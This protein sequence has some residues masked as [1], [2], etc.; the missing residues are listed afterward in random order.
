MTQPTKI[1]ASH[2]D[3][4]FDYAVRRALCM[5]R[6]ENGKGRMECAFHPG[7]P[8][9]W[10]VGDRILRDGVEYFVAG[11][12]YDARNRDWVVRAVQCG[13][14]AAPAR[15]LLQRSQDHRVLERAQLKAARS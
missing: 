3:E 11:I 1:I 8:T 15:R 6:D 9:A 4:M 2:A 14:S 10:T 7:D 5:A 12:I 13:R